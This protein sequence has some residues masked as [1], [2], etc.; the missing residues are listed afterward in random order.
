MEDKRSPFYE[1]FVPALA[2]ASI[3]STCGSRMP[4]MR[5]WPSTMR[6]TA[7]RAAKKGV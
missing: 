2:A 5:A 7:P 6:G 3:T 1:V 4:P